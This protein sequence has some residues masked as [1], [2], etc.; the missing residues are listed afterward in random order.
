M[1]GTTALRKEG[2]FIKV[3]QTEILY[4]EGYVVVHVPVFSRTSYTLF[5]ELFTVVKEM[6]QRRFI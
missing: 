5:G 1:S 4:C 2:C 6:V 3:T